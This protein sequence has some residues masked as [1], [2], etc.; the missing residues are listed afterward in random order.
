MSNSSEKAPTVR[1]LF[2][3]FW[4]LAKPYWVSEDKYRA[5]GLLALVIS[6]SLGLVYMNV[7]FNSWYNEFYNTLQNLDAKGFKSALY[8]FGYL[9]FAYIVIAVYAIWFQQMLE[10]RW[11]RWATL[12]FTQ[13][14]LSENTFY[15]LQL[16]DKATDN[17][18]QRIAEDVG[19]F[20]SISLSLSLGLLRSVVTL[21]SFIGI[22]W[23]LSGPFKLMLGSTAVSIPGY[24]VWV[25]IIYALI[26]TGITILLGRPLVGLN[27]MQQRYEAD[28]RFGLVRVRENAESIALYNGAKDEQERLGYRFVNV[29][30]NFWSVMRMNKRLTWFTSFWG[31]LAIIFPLIV[32]APRFFAK[33]IPLGGLMQINSA[34]GQVYG[35]LDFIIGSFSTLANWKAVIDRLTTFEASIVNA[36]DL[37]RIEPQPIAQGLQLTA[38]S[39]SKPNGEVLLSDVNLTLKAGDALL[40]RGKSGAG[41]STLLRAMAGIWPYAQG[42]YGVQSNT[43]TLFLSQKPY[44][45]LG[46]LRAALYYPHEAEQDDSQISGLL[47]LAGLSHL[48]PR[49]DEVD[50]WS[51]VLSLGEQQ[52]IA[53]LRAMLV[54]PDFLFMD[55]ST[56]ALD[57]EGEDRLY[58]AVAECMKEGV[59]V[60]VGHRAGL[61]EYHEQ[62]LE[63]QGQGAWALSPL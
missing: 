52:R 60:S 11:R 46:S 20:V 38:L 21:V 62:V 41:K 32:A 3:N 51:H 23:S 9:A 58:R 44:M 25:A 15:R 13:R 31:Q 4:Q 56:S 59:M 19:Q 37:P 5:W 24:M 33:E 47:T 61:V 26:G 29:V 28:F 43:R 40:I 1:H 39:V 14:W 36:Q 49:L 17:P 54:K 55:E 53:L 35:A 57:A 7:Q 18:D 34:F 63:C 16:T 6:L 48:M 30:T 42:Q 2:H 22:L 50:A 8:K 10:I 12:H 45:P 27:F